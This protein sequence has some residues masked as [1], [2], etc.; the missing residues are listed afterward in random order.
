[1]YDDE[2]Y[3]EFDERK[4]MCKEENIS[5]IIHIKEEAKRIAQENIN[6]RIEAQR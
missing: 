4:R 1:M 3:K 5:E 2:R 6:I